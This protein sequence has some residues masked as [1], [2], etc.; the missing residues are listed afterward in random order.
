[1]HSLLRDSPHFE[2][3]EYAELAVRQ[4]QM[5]EQGRKPDLHIDINA[6]LRPTLK[7]LP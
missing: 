7:P 6:D 5:V 1:L 4:E 3:V 2:A